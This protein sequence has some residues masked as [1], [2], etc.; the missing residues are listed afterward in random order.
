MS[1]SAGLTPF[2]YLPS[3]FGS[4]A[5]GSSL[6]ASLYGYGGP[7]PGT[8]NPI[9]ALETAKKGEA[10]QVAVISAQPE[11]K[12]DLAQFTKALAAAKTP[13]Q[14]LA[15]PSALKVLLTA[16]GLGDQSGNSALATR[17]LLSD[18]TDTKSLVTRLSD[19]RWLAVNKT[20][21]F[22]T[23]GLS[24]LRDP[25]PS[26]RLPAAMPRCCGAPDWIRPRPACRTRWISLSA[27]RQSP[28]ST[29]YSGIRLFVPY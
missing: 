1:G 29:R 15:N 26:P 21:A 6:L 4:N 17:A 19:S 18:P 7:A 28:A 10:H 3:L 23:K 24:V 2:S 8:V 16:N 25:R 11:V 20:Y 12:R 9:A 5:P 27:P 14:L 22:A 13:A